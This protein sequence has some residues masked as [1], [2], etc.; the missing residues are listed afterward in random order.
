ML[1]WNTRDEREP[2]DCGLVVPRLIEIYIVPWA[3]R[4]KR[5]SEVACALR[6]EW[7]PYVG[8]IA[9]DNSEESLARDAD[10]DKGNLVQQN[11]FADGLPGRTKCVAGK[12]V[13]DDCRPLSLTF[14]RVC[15]NKEPTRCGRDAEVVVGDHVVSRRG[16]HAVLALQDRFIRVGRRA[17]WSVTL[18]RCTQPLVGLVGDHPSL[19][20][21][22]ARGVHNNK[23]LRMSDWKLCQNHAVEQLEDGEIDANSD[24]DGQ[25]YGGDERRCAAK[26]TQCIAGILQGILKPE[27]APTLTRDILNEGQSA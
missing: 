24:G 21:G 26:L 1:W 2:E 23:L 17:D 12:V 15:L 8:G 5:H 10:D 25:Q 3:E 9:C 22:S 18:G 20:E 14:L 19:V 13:T 4:I 7:D 27:P 16:K 11:V 6:L